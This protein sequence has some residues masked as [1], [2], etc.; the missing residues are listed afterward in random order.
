MMKKMK[1]LSE[2]LTMK[3]K[4]NPKE[5]NKKTNF[6][7]V[8]KKA[9][10][11]VQE[12]CLEEITIVDQIGQDKARVELVLAE[13]AQADENQNKTHSTK[14]IN[15]IKQKRSARFQLQMNKE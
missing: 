4:P 11:L 1:K 14:K 6:H 13:E 7:Q 9:E 5:D 10:I 2:L 15:R 12:F 3:L 8:D